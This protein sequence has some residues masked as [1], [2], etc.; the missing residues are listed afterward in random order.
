MCQFV[1]FKKLSDLALFIRIHFSIISLWSEFVWCSILTVQH[2][3]R[4]SSQV[5]SIKFIIKISEMIL[6]WIKTSESF[7]TRSLKYFINTF[8]DAVLLCVLTWEF[9]RRL[10]VL[11]FS[12]NRVQFWISFIQ[13]TF[14]ITLLYWILFSCHT[15]SSSTQL[16]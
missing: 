9:Q 10:C 4:L 8:S 12:S 3:S 2:S 14:F 7:F 1:I 16:S 15:Q 11:K 6:N 13:L 5:M